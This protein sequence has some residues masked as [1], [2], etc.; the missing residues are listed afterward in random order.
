MGCTDSSRHEVGPGPEPWLVG[1]PGEL[2]VIPELSNETWRVPARL[3][4]LPS[5]QTHFLESRWPLPLPPH[6]ML[7]QT[8]GQ[9]PQYLSLSP[10]AP[11]R[12]RTL[13]HVPHSTN[14]DKKGEQPR[15]R[16]HCLENEEPTGRP[17]Q[18]LSRPGPLS[19][20]EAHSRCPRAPCPSSQHCLPDPMLTCRFVRPQSFYN[21][22]GNVATLP[23]VHHLLW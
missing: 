3:S 18:A 12:G 5:P 10:S 14:V 2:A 9:V 22:F 23:C 6:I 1:S 20:S 8:E 21:L 11:S 19:Q 13:L 15:P 4:F 7:R 16:T 17:H